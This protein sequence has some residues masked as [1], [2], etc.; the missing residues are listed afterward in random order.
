MFA[1]KGGSNVRARVSVVLA[2]VLATLVV[3]APGR[4]IGAQSQ[5]DL[6][7]I[8][9]P[10]EVESFD[11]IRSVGGAPA[12]AL[13]GTMNEGLIRI[14]P[15]NLQLQPWLATSWRLVDPQTYIFVLR[16]G[17]KFHDGTEFTADDA[18]FSF[19]LVISTQSWMRIFIPYVDKV[20]VV[21]RYTLRMHS[22]QVDV[23]LPA[24]IG[25][26][27]IYP[28]AYY[29][30]VGT[31]GFATS[32]VL[33]GPYRLARWDRG[34]RVIT[35]RFEGYWGPK[36]HIRQVE[37]KPFVEDATRIAALEA[38]EI[39]LAVSVPPDDAARLEKRG[40]AIK[41]APMAF[42]MVV[43]FKLPADIAQDN[44]IRDRRV[45]QA[46][47]YA[48]DKQ[49]LVKNVMLGYAAPLPGQMVGPDGFGYN[50]A[51]SAYPYDPAKARQLLAEAG[52][53][54]GLT[55]KMDTSQG[56]YTKHKEVSE[57]IVGQLAKVG[58]RVQL[59]V[60][61]WNT[62]L[63]KMFR[64]PYDVAPLSYIGWVYFPSMDGDLAIRWFLSTQ[65]WKFYANP[66][67]DELYRAQRAETNRA[68]RQEILRQIMTLMHDDAPVVFLFR[69]SN[70]YALNPKIGGFVV[71][72][73]QRIRIQDLVIRR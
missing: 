23:L 29:E 22:N 7:R 70:I 19:D 43:Q 60:L 72:P 16:R 30:R 57:A 44:P 8:G 41:W 51:V 32:P 61:E 40:I 67:F 62:Q 13:L 12:T 48:I 46:L 56:Y 55:I 45:R 10:G 71:P 68:K 4:Q 31:Q 27:P 18:K 33:T 36:A 63:A 53:R 47:N 15:Q 25:S 28:K 64:P 42:S 24:T 5:G 6:I 37:W 21:D 52:Y 38:G 9:L 69:Q 50:P 58:V 39:D 73:D 66:K 59:S 2:I 17:V 65:P 49:E 1:H 34:V 54:N 11:S 3:L 26:V 35:E 14:S 20:D